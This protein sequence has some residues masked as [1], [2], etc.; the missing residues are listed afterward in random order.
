MQK[1]K[2]L[3]GAIIAIVIAY[4]GFI[5]FQQDFLA[6][7]FRPMI[8]PL[9]TVYYC[10][11]GGCKRDNFFY[12]LLFYSL[13]ELLGVFYYYATVSAVVDNIMYFGCNLLYVAAYMFLIL[14]VIKSM[15]IVQVVNRFAIHII[16]L[17]I[18]DIY[19]VILVSDVA[20]KSENLV[21]IYD[22]VLEYFYN[23]VIMI[24]LSVALINYLSR[25]SKK[26]M[27]ILLGSLFIVFSEVIQVA[28]FYVSDINILGVIYVILLII[29]FFFLIIQSKM[30]YEESSLYQRSI[31]KVEA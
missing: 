25:D 19:C 30:S 11:N 10:M 17:I 12:F 21:T 18:L 28:Y 6:D 13:S 22:S 26:A 29:A 4:V 8:L 20:I 5:I 14:E 31:N 27:N 23:C 3:L 24:L 16:I 15:N 2:L 9:V 7:I 1:I